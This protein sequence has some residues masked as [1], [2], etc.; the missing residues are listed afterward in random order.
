M[1]SPQTNGFIERSNETV[2]DEVIRKNFHESEKVLQNDLDQW[3]RHYGIEHPYRGY[4]NRGQRPLDTV[5]EFAKP[6]RYVC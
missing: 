1:K 6:A 5:L 2:L 3:L 4:W